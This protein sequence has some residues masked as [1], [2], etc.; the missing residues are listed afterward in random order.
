MDV[1]AR[2]GF[3][4]LVG[5]EGRG[6]KNKMGRTPP[7][8]PQGSP[9]RRGSNDLKGVDVCE[10]RKIV[11]EWLSN[12]YLR[13]MVEEGREEEMGHVVEEIDDSSDDESDVEGDSNSDDESSPP[14]KSEKVFEIDVDYSSL[15]LKGR[16]ENI[17]SRASSPTADS[18]SNSNS[19]NNNN[20]AT[21]F[22]PN[23]NPK[24]SP[25]PSPNPN[26]TT[27][28]NTNTPNPNAN[29]NLCK[30]EATIRCLMMLE[31]SADTINSFFHRTIPS[32][33]IPAMQSLMYLPPSSSL[34][35]IHSIVNLSQSTKKKSTISIPNGIVLRTLELMVGAGNL[36]ISAAENMQLEHTIKAVIDG[37]SNLGVVELPNWVQENQFLD[38]QTNEDKV[39]NAAEMTF[40]DNPEEMMQ[41]EIDKA[42]E[43]QKIPPLTNP[44][45]FWRSIALTLTL[46]SVS[47]PSIGAI[48][49]ETSGTHRGAMRMA[50]SGVVDY[51]GIGEGEDT[52]KEEK[53]RR[54]EEF[55]LTSRLFMPKKIRA[56]IAQIR[57]DRKQFSKDADQTAATV[58]NI[59]TPTE[60]QIQ[61]FKHL[62]KQRQIDLKKKEKELSSEI[63]AFVKDKVKG[64]MLTPT[65]NNMHFR[66]PRRRALNL[67]QS[68]I[69]RFSIANAL[70]SSTSPDFLMSNLKGE[71]TW[72]LPII[73]SNPRIVTRL[74][75]EA[76]VKILLASFK[77]EKLAVLTPPLVSHVG[78]VLK[79]DFGDDGSSLC[80][81]FL[82]KRVGEGGESG[83]VAR[84]ALQE[85]L[86][87]FERESAEVCLGWLP[88]LQELWKGD[89]ARKELLRNCQILGLQTSRSTLLK[90]FALSMD[91]TKDAKVGVGVVIERVM[92]VVELVRESEDFF[93]WCAKALETEILQ[94]QKK[95][96]DVKKDLILGAIN[97]VS[98][99]PE[100]AAEH[101]LNSLLFDV[102]KPN[103]NSVSLSGWITL[104]TSKSHGVSKAASS[105]CMNPTV[106]L[107]S[108][109]IAEDDVT[110][111]LSRVDSP[112][113]KAEDYSYWGFTGDEAIGQLMTRLR[114][115][116][117]IYPKV[118]LSKFKFLSEFVKFEEKAG[119]RACFEVVKEEEEEEV[120]EEDNSSK[121]EAVKQE[122][123]TAMAMD[124]D[125][126]EKNEF[127]DTS[128]SAPVEAV[129]ED[130][131]KSCFAGQTFSL[132]ARSVKALYGDVVS[133]ALGGS[134]DVARGGE[135]AEWILKGC[136]SVSVEREEN[137][138]A[139][140]IPSLLA[141]APDISVSKTKALKLLFSSPKFDGIKDTLDLS[142]VLNFLEANLAEVDLFVVARWVCLVQD[143]VKGF[144][145]VP[146]GK[147]VSVLVKLGLEGIKR[148]GE[149]ADDSRRL[150]LDVAGCSDEGCKLVTNGLAS[151]HKQ[152]SSPEEKERAE[153]A[154]LFQYCEMFDKVMLTNELKMVLFNAAG[155]N[156]DEFV[157]CK[158]NID[159]RFADGLNDLKSTEFSN[160]GRG[161]VVELAKKHPLLVCRKVEMLRQVLLEDATA[162]RREGG[163]GVFTK[164]GGE[165]PKVVE[166]K[167]DSSAAAATS[168]TS[169]STT[170]T[171]TTSTSTSQE[172]GGEG[173]NP[174]PP[175]PQ[176]K[177]LS[178]LEKK[179]QAKLAGYAR[180]EADLN[181]HSERVK[182]FIS[183][184]EEYKLKLSMR[185]RIKRRARDRA[186]RV[187]VEKRAPFV[188][189]SGWTVEEVTRA[190]SAHVDRYYFED[191]SGLK[192]RST[193]EVTA[194]TAIM[195]KFQISAHAAN[196]RY[197]DLRNQGIAGEGGGR[198]GGGDR[199]RTRTAG[200][201]RPQK[202]EEG[203]DSGASEDELEHEIL[204]EQE[205][206]KAMQS[207]RG[208]KR[209]GGGGEE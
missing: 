156:W 109:G 166:E 66:K 98:N 205:K 113:V 86:G 165:P 21:E 145:E 19:N 129:S 42:T 154:L 125:V 197:K 69:K 25:S 9:L 195:N 133:G 47:P 57:L 152:A 67:L 121:G 160:I 198:G 123:D 56:K 141:L 116:E 138:A 20:T 40:F 143:R 177:Q 5:V 130:F 96:N 118:T 35:L 80:G 4:I 161:G 127:E 126:V 122:G 91:P 38:E 136:S 30:L 189:P 87:G 84:K 78:R 112:Q 89:K 95:K 63:S 14:P 52:E 175:T 82:L 32:A 150:L 184:A 68:V 200:G 71:S 110:R 193:V 157:R 201:K 135:V 131:V 207:R 114:Q 106:C 163:S 22:N 115:Y 105:M 180:F 76:A 203:W 119:E 26:N 209:R 167:K 191:R 24:S 158:S 178:W 183:E 100:E 134:G 181:V 107:L 12:V 61:D 81:E 172:A 104:L 18:S 168:M 55:T 187:A 111:L 59:P 3:N 176:P 101:K 97:V 37:I 90:H 151:M 11:V 144:I 60:K 64:I 128:V 139:R 28:T 7:F 137:L 6:R 190:G 54:D 208:T 153:K 142:C 13:R 8:G 140:L 73:Q 162:G 194:I 31:L 149:G 164:V 17:V 70:R 1:V 93:S 36:T 39:Q 102:I 124:M 48:V 2:V 199:K 108:S 53:T 27:T 88:V 196:K 174:R 43:A 206:M 132:L 171:S 58:L 103:P 65:K 192:L 74:P 16:G 45:V 44:S 34:P 33:A 92:D 94:L 50:C 75:G 99:A 77:D 159:G 49:Y 147:G 173:S 148:G 204:K 23:P 155:K 202:G 169:T 182:K 146:G 62:R 41:A 85:C 120:K 185:E 72:L 83:R 10:V 179:H 79:G 188:L 117:R 51:P 186:S 170:S 46:A 15:L 29:S